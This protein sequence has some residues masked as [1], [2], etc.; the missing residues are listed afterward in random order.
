[1][2]S[3]DPLPELTLVLQAAVPRDFGGHLVPGS[4]SPEARMLQAALAS[5]FLTISHIYPNFLR[6]GTGFS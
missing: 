3:W 4:L 2:R 6:T 5:P 1:M